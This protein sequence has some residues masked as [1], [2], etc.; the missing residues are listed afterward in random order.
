M[1]NNKRTQRFALIK[2]IALIAKMALASGLAW[3]LAKILGS[4]HPYLAPLTV[5]LSMQETVIY[6]ATY[7]LYRII[8]TVFGVA[9]TFFIVSHLQVNGWTIGGLLFGGMLIPV[10]FRVHKTIIH[11]VALT[12]LLVFVFAHKTSD[13]SFDRIRDTIVGA[14]TVLFVHMILFPPNYVKEARQTLNQFGFHLVQLFKR[15]AYWVEHNCFALEGQELKKDVTNLLQELHQVQKDL[16]LAKKSLKFNPFSKNKQQLLQQYE[17]FLAQ[18]TTGYMY[19]SDVLTTFKDWAK[20]E[21]MSTTEQQQWAA[22]LQMLGAYIEK[23]LHQKVKEQPYS[24]ALK[25]TPDLLDLSSISAQMMVPTELKEHRYA[26]SLY[27]QTLQFIQELKT[28][29]Q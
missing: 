1:K 10:I 25:L 16:Q 28:A 6:S 11:Q 4:K 29:Q 13:Y 7:A 21:T 2:G 12:I 8:G 22:Q 19:I 14:I 20:T 23:R 27:H 24:E 15:T 5:I 17:Q 18:L 3:K 9:V 26:L